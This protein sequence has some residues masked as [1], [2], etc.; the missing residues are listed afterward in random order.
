MGSVRNGEEHWIFPFQENADSMFNSA[1][2]CEM[3]LFKR[4]ALPLLEQVPENVNEKTEA[5]RLIKLL[6][7]F[8]EISDTAVP[9]YSILREFFGGSVFSY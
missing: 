8:T 4:Y 6:N 7:Y 3:S 2:L 5:F 1:M 9:H